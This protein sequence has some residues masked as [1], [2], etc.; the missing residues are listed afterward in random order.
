MGLFD[1]GNVNEAGL[2]KQDPIIISFKTSRGTNAKCALVL[3]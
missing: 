3:F 2:I 1:S